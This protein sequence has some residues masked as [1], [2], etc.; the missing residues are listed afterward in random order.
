M[1]KLAISRFL[2]TSK[3]LATESGKELSDFISYVSDLADQSLRALRNGVGVRDNLDA[4]VKAVTVKHNTDAIVNT[5]GRVPL[6]VMPTYQATSLASMVSGF[7]WSVNQQGQVVVR[8]K[9]D[10]AP[11][12]SLDISLVILF[13]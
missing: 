9:F 13:S 12:T 5:D 3:F 11:S 2:E 1:T 4:V 8:M 7:A 10:N 6:A